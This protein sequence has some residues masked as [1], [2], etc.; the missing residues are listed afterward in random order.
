MTQNACNNDPKGSACM[1]KQDGDKW[2]DYDGGTDKF[3]LSPRVLEILVSALQTASIDFTTDGP[4]KPWKA[5][6][7]QFDPSTGAHVAD[8]AFEDV[9]YNFGEELWY[10]A[11]NNT[12][13]TL[14]NGTVVY[15]SG[16]SVEQNALEID[17]AIA[18]I[19]PFAVKTL[20]FVTA[21]IADG[22][23]GKVTYFGRVGGLNTITYEEGGV[24]WLSAD[25]AG[26]ATQTKPSVGNQLILLGSV[27]KQD[28][29]DGEF[30]TTVNPTANTVPSYKSET[31]SSRGV[32]AGTYYLFGDY[33]A[34][35]ADITLTDTSAT[36]DFGTE[37]SA[38][39]MR[40]FAVFAGDGAVDSGQIG[41]RVTG[42]TITDSGVR[43]GSDTQVITEDI[44]TPVL[45]DYL[46]P[47]K[48]F[49]GAVVY[50]LYVVSGSPTS[51]SVSFNYGLVKYEDF[52]NRDF[53]VTDLEVVGLGGAT[54]TGFVLQLLKQSSDGWAY[55][56]D[57]FAP[58]NGVIADLNAIYA[59]EDN[60]IN[61]EAFHFK[62][63]ST[64]L[65]DV[66]LGSQNEGLLLKL[67][68]TQ[69]NT[70]QYLN[71]HVGASF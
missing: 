10:P 34:P 26:L 46:E 50:E 64:A 32:G 71:C 52:G 22:E 44:T 11:C 55:S 69:N 9:R 67:V 57:D 45:N 27:V 39:G 33:I 7:I 66:I 35:E 62:L 19:P 42:T 65:S 54:D 60:I 16:V 8:T 1:R 23:C 3:I 53:L 5:G 6:Q 38:Y 68:T 20:G 40:P 48:K 63:D 21:D 14:V 49:I 12:G 37:N 36:L 31:F 47:E 51:Y 13:D 59:P 56:A 61:G 4:L 29:E 17:K 30:W 2:F 43:T 18:S 28:E 15:A 24:L 25:T 70:I 58:G 41:L